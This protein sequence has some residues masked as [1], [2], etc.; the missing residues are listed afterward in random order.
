[1]LIHCTPQIVLLAVDRMVRH[2][3][4]DLVNEEC[5]TVTAVLS[6]QTACTNGTELDAA[7]AD[8]FAADGYATFSERTLYVAVT[9]IKSILQ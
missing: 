7:E 2:T 1:M 3:G 5:V 4:E 6:F 9:Q 8:R